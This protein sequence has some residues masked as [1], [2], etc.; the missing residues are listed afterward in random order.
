MSEGDPRL[1]MF[2]TSDPTARILDRQAL[3]S[4]GA[5][6]AMPGEAEE[7]AIN[8]GQCEEQTGSVSRKSTRVTIPSLKALEN[9]PD[10]DHPLG[11]E[12]PKTY[13]S[14]V[15]TTK[16]HPQLLKGVLKVDQTSSSHWQTP[17]GLGTLHYLI[18]NL[19]LEG[20]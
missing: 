4:I 10:A 20:L 1:G 14:H 13:I 19:S 9:I 3:K 12:A 15:G 5:L 17:W 6:P 7:K 8:P 16:T 2:D 11:M 18:K